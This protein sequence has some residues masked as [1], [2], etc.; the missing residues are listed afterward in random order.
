M[1][2]FQKEVQRDL[3]LPHSALAEANLESPFT[4]MIC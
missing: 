1:K 2:N 3:P 4:L